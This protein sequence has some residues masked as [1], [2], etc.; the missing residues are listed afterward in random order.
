MIKKT[1]ND[2]VEISNLNRQ[3]LYRKKDIEKSKSACACRE[4][5]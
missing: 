4:K 3:F 2:N 1:D 5:K